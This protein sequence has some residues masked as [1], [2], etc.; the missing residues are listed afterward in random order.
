[1]LGRIRASTTAT[2]KEDASEVGSP[3]NASS[4]MGASSGVS[5]D[6]QSLILPPDVEGGAD[7][8]MS[9]INTSNYGGGGIKTQMRILG[10]VDHDEE[11]PN[12][13]QGTK[14]MIQREEARRLQRKRAEN[15]RKHN[16]ERKAYPAGS[17]G[18]NDGIKANSTGVSKSMDD[19]T[20]VSDGP[21]GC[22]P[23]WLTDAPMWL[24]LVI[25]LST[26]LLVGAIVLIGVGAALAV[27]EENVLQAQGNNG[28]GGS[29]LP[30]MTLVPGETDD[31]D[32]VAVTSPPVRPGTRPPAASTKAPTPKATGPTASPTAMPT[33]ETVTFYA[34]GGRFTGDARTALPDQLKTLPMIDGGTVMF[35]LGDW[36]SPFATSCNELSYQE[37]AE[38]YANSAVPVYFVPGDNEFNGEY[39]VFHSK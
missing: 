7:D 9:S 28:D 36:N 35:H 26:A 27:K 21:R 6:G 18:R 34:T 3:V 23:I 10:T 25:V 20:E 8:D 37:N 12:A 13:P 14:E 32:Y 33:S 22:L 30:P 19:T 24:K 31:E 16:Y 1:M 5:L 38:L 15:A 4:L 17:S 2:S 39:Y 29:E 11:I